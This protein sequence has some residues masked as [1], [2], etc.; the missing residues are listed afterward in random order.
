MKKKSWNKEIFRI[1]G[2]RICLAIASY[3]AINQATDEF[4]DQFITIL[5]EYSKEIAAIVT[6]LFMLKDS[7][8]ILKKIIKPSFYLM[9]VLKQSFNSIRK[10][11]R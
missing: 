8:E 2:L 3:V 11:R 5:S 4:I 6:A 7:S 9:K 10:K 1:V